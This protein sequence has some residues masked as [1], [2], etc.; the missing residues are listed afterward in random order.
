MCSLKVIQILDKIGKGEELENMVI[1]LLNFKY[2][3]K[4]FF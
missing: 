4:L 1:L 3:F 2:E